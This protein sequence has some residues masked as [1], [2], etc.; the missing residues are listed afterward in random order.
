[1]KNTISTIVAIGFI[2]SMLVNT[3]YAGGRN[4]GFINPLWIPV[5]ILS[6]LAAV[7]IA[8]PQPVVYERRITYEPRQ[9]VIYE[10]PRHWRERNYERRQVVY[11][12]EQN[13]SY[14]APRYHYR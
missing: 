13:R 4:G 8:Q 12:D 5:A 14:E 11:H 9:T 6:T 7:T 3:A 10:E 1:M 2:S